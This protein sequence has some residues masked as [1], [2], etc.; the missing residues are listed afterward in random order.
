[1]NMK[2]RDELSNTKGAFEL[3]WTAIKSVLDT[4]HS[5][6]QAAI[7]SL[8]SYVK[9]LKGLDTKITLLEGK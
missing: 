8:E 1:M 5:T 4:R 6:R 7:E 9:L 3:T 2:T